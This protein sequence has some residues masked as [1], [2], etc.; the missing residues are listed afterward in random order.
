MVDYLID[1]KSIF[2]LFV[3]VGFPILNSDFVQYVIDGLG[4]EYQSFITLLHFHSS[5]IFDKLYDLLICKKHLQKKH[6]GM[7][8]LVVIIVAT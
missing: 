2:D 1:A 6:S 3:T 4:L 5:T 8:T 7:S